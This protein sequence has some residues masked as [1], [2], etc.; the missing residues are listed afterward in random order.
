M[1][2]LRIVAILAMIA[3]Q[4]CSSPVPEPPGAGGPPKMSYDRANAEC[5]NDVMGAPHD[6]NAPSRSTEFDMCMRANGWNY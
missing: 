4:G 2:G 5:W 6:N 1:T 3:A